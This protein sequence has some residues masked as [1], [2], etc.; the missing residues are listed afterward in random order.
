MHSIAKLIKENIATG[1]KKEYL[2]VAD[3]HVFSHLCRRL[4]RCNNF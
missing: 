4:K 1:I 2:L 3:I